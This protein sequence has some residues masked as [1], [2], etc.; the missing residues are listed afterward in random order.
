MFLYAVSLA[1]LMA[2]TVIH[3][4]QTCLAPTAVVPCPA[5][6][7]SVQYYSG[8]KDTLRYATAE[9]VLWQAHDLQQRAGLLAGEVDEQ[10]FRLAAALQESH[11]LRGLIVEVCRKCPDNSAPATVACPA[12]C[13][14]LPL[15]P[16][17]KPSPSMTAL[18]AEPLDYSKDMTQSLHY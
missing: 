2:L 15:W 6:A 10:K 12:T 14:H 3:D 4:C 11:N 1:F 7:L 9:V 16:A 18:H 17:I 5:Q 13:P 8:A